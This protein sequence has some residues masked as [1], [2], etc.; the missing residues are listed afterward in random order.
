VPLPHQADSLARASTIGVSTADDLIEKA[1]GMYIEGY[2]NV[3]GIGPL[4]SV[5]CVTDLLTTFPSAPSIHR[6]YAG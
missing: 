4:N 1:D 3:Q 5:M 2:K 6:D